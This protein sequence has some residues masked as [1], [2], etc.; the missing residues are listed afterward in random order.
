MKMKCYL[1]TEIVTKI[2]C[3]FLIIMQAY[4]VLKDHQSVL[5][6]SKKLCRKKASANGFDVFL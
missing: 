1:F 3:T 5:K 4:E 2:W 6:I